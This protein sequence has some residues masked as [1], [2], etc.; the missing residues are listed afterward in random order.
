MGL[1]PEQATLRP[2]MVW[3]AVQDTVRVSPESTSLATTVSVS[4]CVPHGRVD[5]EREHLGTPARRE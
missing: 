4:V 1:V 2:P 5:A 3:S